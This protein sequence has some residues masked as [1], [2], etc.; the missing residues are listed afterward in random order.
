[1]AQ[2]WR[3]NGA[4]NDVLLCAE[5]LASAGGNGRRELPVMAGY[6]DPHKPGA[7]VD[8]PPLSALNRLG[9]A[10]ARGHASGKC[11]AEGS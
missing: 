8:K 4:V 11:R 6:F 7:E 9:S 3:R 2:E 5:L 1:M 10:S